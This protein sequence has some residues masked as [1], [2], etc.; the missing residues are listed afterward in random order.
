MKFP[1]HSY[2]EMICFISQPTKPL[3]SI[4][5]VASPP[6]GT[7][8]MA[9]LDSFA[10]DYDEINDTNDSEDRRVLTCESPRRSWSHRKLSSFECAED[11]VSRVLLAFQRQNDVEQGA[12]L[13]RK[14]MQVMDRLAKMQAHKRNCIGKLSDAYGR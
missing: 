12:R 3:R 1:Y 10:E 4:F 2:F 5:S 7:E 9:V 6:W 8:V 11:A 14:N 13:G